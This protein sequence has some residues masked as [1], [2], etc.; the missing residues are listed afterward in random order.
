MHSRTQEILTYL[1]A[2]H[3]ALA[4]AVAV[5]HSEATT[6]F[7]AD[8]MLGRLARWL[9]AVGIDTVYGPNFD[10]HE[11]VRRADLEDRV[12]LTRDRH[13]VTHLRPRRA[14][15]LKS[16]APLEQLREVVSACALPPP[17]EL[18]TR[19]LVCNSLLVPLDRPEADVL[20]P[21]RARQLPGDV[22]HCPECD[23]VFW[24][25]SHVRRMR[26]ALARTIP[27]WFSSGQGA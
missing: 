26:S 5:D 7:V 25:G 16:Q 15:L 18:F 24:P 9:R 20:L 19:C 8:A 10:D 4:D 3:A 14:L 17:K 13:L 23:Q 1:G 27:E 22:R 11:L 12:L 6:R 2:Q 21:E